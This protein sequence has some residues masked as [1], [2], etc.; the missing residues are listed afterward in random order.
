MRAVSRAR[1]GI[2]YL[3]LEVLGQSGRLLASRVGVRPPS[4]YKAAQRGRAA[5]ARW[6]CV[7]ND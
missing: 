2:A 1:E 5:A 6:E 7:L 3:W 4:V